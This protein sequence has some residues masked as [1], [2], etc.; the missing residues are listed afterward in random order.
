MVLILNLNRK[1]LSTLFINPLNIHP[2]NHINDI[3][4]YWNQAKR[5]MRKFNAIAK[6]HFELYLNECYW[7]FNTPSE[8]HQLT[9]LE[10]T[11][12]GKN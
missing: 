1:A 6:V 7:C 2:Q 3:E 5:H 8:K 11:V 10:Q 9:I 4:N 12:K